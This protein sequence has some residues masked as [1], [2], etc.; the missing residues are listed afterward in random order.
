MTN[1]TPALENSLDDVIKQL[2]DIVEDRDLLK[3]T[4]DTGTV[5]RIAVH[6]TNINTSIVASS[7]DH[8]NA[9]KRLND[10]ASALTRIAKNSELPSEALE[11]RM[12]QIAARLR[13]V[14]EALASGGKNSEGTAVPA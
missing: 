3:S 1:Y 2:R 11:N 7:E 14:S 4:I 9:S 8:V 6:V 10:F 5:Q 12:R 13:S